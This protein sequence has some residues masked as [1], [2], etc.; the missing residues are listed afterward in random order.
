VLDAYGF[1]PYTD[2][3]DP[4]DVYVGSKF[5]RS[6]LDHHSASCLVAVAELEG[7]EP[8]AG[9]LSVISL[10]PY[11]MVFLPIPLDRPII[12][13]HVETIARQEVGIWL[14]S[15]I[16]LLDAIRRAAPK[17][18]IPLDDGV[19]SDAVAEQIDDFA[20]L[21]DGDDCSLS[22]DERTAWLLLYEGAR[23][24]IAHGVALTLAG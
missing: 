8:G 5:G 16:G 10:N 12:T 4:P 14:C 23:L 15:S 9:H 2:P 13:E 11:R 21:Y 17:L 20:P 7:G 6:S 18:G 24:S 3:V 19:L 22:E 1:E